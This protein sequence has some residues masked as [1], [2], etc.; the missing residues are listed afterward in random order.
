MPS[1]VRYRVLKK[2]VFTVDNDAIDFQAFGGKR[3]RV[4]VYLEQIED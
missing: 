4:E 1:K 2:E 3:K